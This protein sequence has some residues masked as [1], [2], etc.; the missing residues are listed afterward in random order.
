MHDLIII[1]TG[2]AG[3]TAG[4]FSGLYKLNTLIVGETL[5]GELKL[6]PNILDYPGIKSIKGSEWLEN[7]F[8]QLKEVNVD[9]LEEKVTKITPT[10]NEKLQKIFDIS[11]ENNNYSSYAIILAVG[12]KNRRPSYSGVDLAFKSGIQTTQ[13]NFIKTNDLQ[14]TNLAGVYAAGN[15]IAFPHATEQLVDAA[16]LGAKA[17]A[18][19]YEY[20]KKQKPPIIW[21]KATI[22]H[23]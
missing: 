13:N 21:G 3:L 17:S 14:Q 2:P 7:M 6:A 10:T 15:C 20:L 23:K 8:S 18:Q 12:N 11:T 4:L 16:A 5:G 9:L 19:V 1:G 22:P